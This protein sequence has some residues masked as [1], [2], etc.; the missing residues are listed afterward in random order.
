MFVVM[1]IV[2]KG[3]HRHGKSYPWW[4]SNIYLKIKGWIKNTLL[5]TQ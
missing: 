5:V 2:D 3:W 4:A 1:G